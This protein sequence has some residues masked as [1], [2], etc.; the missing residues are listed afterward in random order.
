MGLFT[1]PLC[2][3]TLTQVSKAL[4][5]RATRIIAADP[6]VAR[7]GIKASEAREPPTATDVAVPLPPRAFLPPLHALTRGGATRAHH[8]VNAVSPGWVRTD[9]GG[10]AAE[11]PVAEGAARV[12]AVVDDTDGHTGS[13]YSRPKG[14]TD[15]HW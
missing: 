7:R 12:L 3:E 2:P 14:W 5:N 4:L 10:A 1:L 6:E 9:M 11:L 13:F 15:T 8:Q